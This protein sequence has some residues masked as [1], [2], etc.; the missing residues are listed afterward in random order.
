[1]PKTFVGEKQRSTVHCEN[2]DEH[3]RVIVATRMMRD[4]LTQREIAKRIG[5]TPVTLS[6]RLAKPASF[7][8]GELRRLSVALEMTDTETGRCV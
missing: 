8:I 6:R 5:L 1:M 2:A 3:L 7:T 4:R